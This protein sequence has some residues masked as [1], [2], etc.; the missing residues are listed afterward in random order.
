MFNST[1]RIAS[2][3]NNGRNSIDS[4]TNDIRH[5][6]GL[7]KHLMIFLKLLKRPSVRVLP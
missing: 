3:K 6:I 2:G 5:Y 1:K 7:K 4:D